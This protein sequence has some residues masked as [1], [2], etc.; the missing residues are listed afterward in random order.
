MMKRL[1]NFSEA[2]LPVFR[3]AVPAING[4]SLGWLERYFAFFSAV[5]TDYFCH[6]TGTHIAGTAVSTII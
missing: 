4:S 6:F 5:C 3:Q 2:G 1:R